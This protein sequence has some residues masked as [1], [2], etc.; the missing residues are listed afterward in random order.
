[1]IASIRNEKK[2]VFLIHFFHDIWMH[3]ALLRRSIWDDKISVIRGNSCQIVN[4]KANIPV[5]GVVSPVVM[6]K[7]E[8]SFS[9]R[10]GPL[11]VLTVR[12]ARVADTPHC[13]TANLTPT[14]SQHTS[15]I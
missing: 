10:G 6:L 11:P 4:I 12:Q 5:V 15:V 7:C 2:W 1:M 14:N 8:G 3:D 9:P 13:I